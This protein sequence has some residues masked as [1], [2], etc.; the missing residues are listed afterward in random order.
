VVFGIRPNDIYD[1]KYAPDHVKGS[2]LK[3]AVDVI[4][5]LGSEIHSNV[6]SGPLPL[7]DAKVTLRVII[8]FGFDPF[9]N[10]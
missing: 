10:G 9:E 1:R 2:Y 7:P 6:T 3:A 4:E 8:P 5:P